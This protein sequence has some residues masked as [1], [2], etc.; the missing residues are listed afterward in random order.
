M[1]Q[2]EE[3]ITIDQIDF[4]WVEKCTTLKHLKRAHQVLKQDGTFLFSSFYQNI[5]T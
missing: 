4:E 3:D 5:E 1:F 2:R